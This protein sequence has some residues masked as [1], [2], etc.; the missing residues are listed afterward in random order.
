MTS[1]K[2]RKTIVSRNFVLASIMCCIVMCMIAT[3]ASIASIAI[4]EFHD[5]RNA[6]EARVVNGDPAFNVRHQGAAWL[7]DPQQTAIQYA[8]PDGID[9]C[10][11]LDVN[12]VTIQAQEAVIVVT[13]NCG[14]DSTSAAR[15]RVELNR[16]GE[17]WEIAWVGRKQRCSRVG[18]LGHLAG[19]GGWTTQ[20]C[21]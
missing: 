17:V 14:D 16:N 13:A 7:K 19:Q 2:V 18:I 6:Y 20:P 21:P 1:S 4:E 5:D 12:P 3:L 9:A 10:R 8:I 15:Y 11:K